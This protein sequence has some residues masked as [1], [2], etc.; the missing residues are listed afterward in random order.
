[1]GG[2]Q[3]REVR[4]L[5][6]ETEYSRCKRLI[7]LRAFLKGY[8]NSH[9]KDR[10]TPDVVFTGTAPGSLFAV[11]P[12]HTSFSYGQIFHGFQGSAEPFDAP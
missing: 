12:S 1:M 11:L 4:I 10:S 5:R 9:R 2:C 8:I 6:M 3:K 7:V